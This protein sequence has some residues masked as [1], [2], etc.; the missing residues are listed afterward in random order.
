MLTS[1]AEEFAMKLEALVEEAKR[2]PAVPLQ[3]ATAYQDH[4]PGMRRFVDGALTA[5]PGIPDLIG[6]N[7]RQMMYDNHRHHGTFM[8]TVFAINGFSLLARTLPWVYRAYHAHGFAYYYFLLEMKA[9]LAAAELNLEE[10]DFKALRP[11][12]DWMIEKH[13]QVVDLAESSATLP[14]T[15]G[16]D[17]FQQ[18]EVF[19]A[20]LLEGDHRQCLNLATGAVS[21]VDDIEN[22]Y[23]HILQPCLY[24][25]GMRWEKAEISVAQEHLASAIVTRVMASLNLLAHP[26]AERRG[27]AVVTAGPNEYHEIGALM[28]SDVLENDG[29]EVNYLGANVPPE[30]LLAHLRQFRPEMLAI[31]VTIPFNLGDLRGLVQT[32]RQDQDLKETK[33]LAGGRVFLENPELWQEIGAD[34]FAANAQEAKLQARQWLREGRSMRGNE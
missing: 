1:V 18:K 7:S 9:W 19:L 23:L 34:G 20:A 13:D 27:R 11:I 26:A 17:S 22:F 8:A 2:L 30:E 24:E 31:S 33:I 15:I 28:V 6:N 10:K 32:I 4:L 3:T 25:I 16:E 29:W 21:T 14:P 5:H 12:Y